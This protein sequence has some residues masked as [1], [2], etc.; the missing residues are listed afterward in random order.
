MRIHNVTVPYNLNIFCFG[1]V[2]EGTK[3][4]DDEGWRKCLSMLGEEYAGVKHNLAVDHGDIVEAVSIDHPH[5][6]GMTTEGNVYQQMQTAMKD[7]W[8]LRKKF[9]LVMDGNHPLRFWKFFGPNKPGLTETVCNDL[10]VRY[11]GFVSVINYMDRKGDRMF[12]QYVT[13]P[14][15]GSSDSKVDDPT[16]RKTNMQLSIK[17]KLKDQV[18][19]CILMTVGHYHKLIYCRPEPQLYMV[20]DGKTL[21]GKYTAPKKT[22]G[23]IHPDHRHY[24]CTGSFHR[25]FGNGY[26][27]YS[28]M[29]GY[30]P[31]ELGFYIVRVRNRKIEGI[32]KILI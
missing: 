24:L 22:S 32:D 18:G 10:G 13:H 12:G 30:S 11:G 25:T 14:T 2:H 23:F 1:D 16:R 15:R 6:D 29:A 5:Y 4:K 28:E 20:N 3:A 9:I 26:D 21:H 31:V 8:A 17:K 19:D 27:T 7:R